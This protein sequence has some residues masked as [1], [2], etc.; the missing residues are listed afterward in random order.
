[1][2]IA[3]H[4]T[5]CRVGLQ[6][7]R[8]DRKREI[9][10]CQACGRLVD[11]R[12]QLS[13]AAPGPRGPSG[14]L[15]PAVQLP[16]GMML[17]TLASGGIE[18]R[19]PWLRSKHWAFLLLCAAASAGVA[20]FWLVDGPSGWLVAATL[21]VLNWDFM[22]L[23]MFVNLTTI[24]ATPAGVEVR[25]G[26]LPSL[27]GR[28]V[29]LGQSELKQLFVAQHGAAF[30]V[31]AQLADDSVKTLVAPLVSAEQA[32]FVEQRLEKELGLVDFEVEGELGVSRE[33]GADGEP[34]KGARSGAAMALLVPMLVLGALGLFF[35]MTNTSVE[36]SLQGA[37]ELGGWSFTPDDC[38]SGEREGFG[39]VVLT[40]DASAGRALRVV[41]DP[42][43]G[44]LLVVVQPGRDNVVLDKAGCVT[45]DVRTVRSNTNVNDIWAI[46]GRVRVECPSLSGK[47]TFEGCH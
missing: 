22:V 47:L 17:A 26:P 7:G 20:R 39:G 13:P 4:C 1:M 11:I 35:V 34:L 19:R 15:R 5:H 16:P 28:N 24:R 14:R 25:H 3:L 33:L 44:T 21:F 45:F 32:L 36:G 42:V 43:K 30:A 18:L 8:V 9:A 38:V 29:R 46:D 31:K 6:E 2:S 37:G 12:P 10:T 40:S 23:A 27:F 41:N